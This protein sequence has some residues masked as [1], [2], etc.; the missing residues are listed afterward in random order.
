MSSICSDIAGVMTGWVERSA[1]YLINTMANLTY[2][3][4]RTGCNWTR[5]AAV[6]ADDLINA[7]LGKISGRL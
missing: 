6:T 2:K 4:V 5:K 7:T 1:P 3:A